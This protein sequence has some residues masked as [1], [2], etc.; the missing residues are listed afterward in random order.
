MGIL[1]ALSIITVAVKLLPSLIMAAE[2]LFN[3]PQAG[4]DRK[5]YVMNLIKVAIGFGEQVSGRDIVDEAEF[6]AGLEQATEGVLR[7]L[8]ATK[9]WN[10][11]FPK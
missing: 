9:V 2:A 11:R 3:R 6:L 1:S 10:D 7:A 5:A 4:G 8:K